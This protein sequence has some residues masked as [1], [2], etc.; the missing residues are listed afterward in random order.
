MPDFSARLASL[1][2]E[3]SRDDGHDPARLAR[4]E[5]TRAE[6][7]VQGAAIRATLQPRAAAIA[8]SRGVSP[9][10]RSPR[11]VRAAA[12]PGSSATRSGTQSRP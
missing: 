6:M 4:V 3:P 8:T 9:T 5:R 7:M 1:V 10:A 11:R 12:I 2:A